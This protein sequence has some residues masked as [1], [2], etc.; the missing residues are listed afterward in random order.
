MS[1]QHSPDGD[2]PP[3]PTGAGTATVLLSGAVRR[4]TRDGTG[5]NEAAGLAQY[6]AQAE[7]RE[8]GTAHPDLPPA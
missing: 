3:R 8:P 1:A 6:G 7:L 4:V 2:C 5:P